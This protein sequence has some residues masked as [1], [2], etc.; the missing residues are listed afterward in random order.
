[1]IY[2]IEEFPHIALERIRR[3]PPILTYYP[4][5]GNDDLSIVHGIKQIYASVYRIGNKISKRD[6][7]GIHA[8]IERIALETMSDII[9]ASLMPK[10]QKQEIL[11]SVRV[12]LEVLKHLIRTEHESGVIP[13]KSYMEL[14]ALLVETSK[15]TN[16]WIRY[17]AQN[18]AR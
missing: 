17:L 15:M 7:L 18:P 3:N 11:E 13:E 10:H 12:S 9:R 5:G 4:P 6:K 2:G 1:M 14:A 8:H 16:G